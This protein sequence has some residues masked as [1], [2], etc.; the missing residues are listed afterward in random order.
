MKSL[1]E[2]KW[3]AKKNGRLNGMKI[4]QKVNEMKKWH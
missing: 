1:M 2:W 4:K 3:N